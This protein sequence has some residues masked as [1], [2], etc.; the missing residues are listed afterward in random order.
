MEFDLQALI[1][2]IVVLLIFIFSGSRRRKTEQRSPESTPEID[3]SPDSEVV[4]PPF[5][6]NF[7]GFPSRTEFE[8]ET[9]ESSEEG[10]PMVVEQ[11]EPEPVQEPTPVKKPI[12]PLP[13]PVDSPTSLPT[14]PISAAFLLNPSLETFRQ[15]IIL[16]EVLGKPK[17]LRSRQ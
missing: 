8:D 6:E 14:R 5:M 2:I 13:V 7:E 10:I 17:G 11:L 12:K 1:P 9:V 15:G 4:L 3:A 16:A